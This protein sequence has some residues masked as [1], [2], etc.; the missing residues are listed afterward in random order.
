MPMGKIYFSIR[1]CFVFISL[2]I[3]SQ[4][5]SQSLSCNNGVNISMDENCEVRLSSSLILRGLDAQEDPTNFLISV[6]TQDGAIPQDV[7]V[8][9]ASTNTFS[10]TIGPQG[11]FLL[12]S[13]PG[14]FI[15]NV[16]RKS[17]GISCWSDLRVED[18]L[19]PFAVDCPC[20]ADVP[21][22]A[23]CFLSCAAIPEFRGSSDVSEAAGLN[24]IFMDNCEL[25]VDVS[26]R[27]E[28]TLDTG[29]GNYIITRTW[30]SL[31]PDV[32]GT[33]VPR[34]LRCTQRFFFEPA[35]IDSIIP[36]SD[37]VEVTCGIDTDPLSLRDYFSDTSFFSN[38][39]LDTALVRAYPSISTMIPGFGSALTVIGEGRSGNSTDNFC[40]VN[41]SYTDSPMIPG[42]G[43]IGFKFVRTWNIIDWCSNET[44]PNVTQIIKVSDTEGPRF[45]IPDTIV[46]VSTRS[47]A[48]FA[49]IIVPAPD[50]LYD[51]CTATSDLVWIAFVEIDGD[52]IEA[53]SDNGNLLRNLPVGTHT[54]TYAVTD[55]CDNTSEDTTTIV[56]KDLIR[57]V[58]IAK[59]SIKITFASFNGDCTAKV[60]T[61]NIDTG[62]FDNCDDDLEIGI[63]RF[64]SD[65][66]FG[67]SVK[68]DGDDL[69]GVSDDGN[70]TGEVIIELEVRDDYDNVNLA[71]TTVKLQDLRSNVN[72]TCGE[73]DIDVNCT[74]SLE[75]EII[76]NAPT[77]ILSGCTDRPLEV[78]NL[79]RESNI[80][81]SCNTGTAIV[82]YFIEG[83]SDVICTKNFELSDP[84]TI[85]II[86]PEAEITVT[87]S[88]SDFGDPIIT[89]GLCSDPNVSE[90]IRE[91][92]TPIG[93]GFCRTLIREITVTDF[94]SFVPNSGDS[95]G[96]FRFT[97]RIKVEDNDRPSIECVNLA[98]DSNE[99][100]GASGIVLSASG[101]DTGICND[102]LT[103]FAA[104][105]ADGDGV[106]EIELEVTGEENVTAVVP[107]TIPVGLHDVRWRALDSCGNSDEAV[108]LLTVVDT[109][110]PRVRCLGAI[111]TASMGTDGTV[112][113]WAQDFDPDG[114]STDDC[115]DVLIYSF[116]PTIQNMPSMTFT[117]EDLVA[118]VGVVIDLD[119]HVFD[120]SGN[121]DFCSVTIR[122]DDNQDAC[123][124]DSAHNDEEEEEEEEEDGG[125]GATS[126]ISG[127]IATPAGDRLESA[128]VQNLRISENEVFEDM[129]DIEGTYAFSNNAL[130]TDYEISVSLEGDVLNGVSTLDLVLIQRHILGLSTLDSPYKL[131]AADVTEDTRIS[132][133]DLV[134]I[135]NLILGR[136]QEFASGNSWR[137]IPSDFV[138]ADPSFPW[139]ITESIQLSQLSGDMTGQ[140]FIGI[141]LG[142]VNNNAIANSGLAGARSHVIAPTVIQDKTYKAGERV[143]VDIPLVQY[144]DV[145]GL[146][147][148]L[149]IP[150]Q[151]LPQVSIDG[152][153]L[154]EEN[155]VLDDGKLYLS[156]SAIGGELDES[157]VQIA[158]ISAS[159]GVLSD[160]LSMMSSFDSEIYFGEDLDIG[161][162]Q[163]QYSSIVD[164]EIV[165]YQN[166]PNPF[167]DQTSIS[168]KIGR[169][170]QVDLTVF[171]LTGRQLYGAS[172]VYES[173][174][175]TIILSQ[176]ILDQDGVL[177]YQINFE[178][179]VITKKM[180]SFR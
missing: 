166:T 16:V 8:Y 125:D 48:C 20:A 21:P 54:V 157:I 130:M 90:R 79:I 164:E 99:E 156:L 151:W 100:C 131:I 89:G 72:I 128:V 37:R 85:S 115:D 173:G 56:I 22:S 83:S 59:R 74:A 161:Q 57:P 163:L 175:H 137:F 32:D 123:D 94:C 179:K 11:E 165:L 67:D 68:F 150:G 73:L 142:D 114:L 78:T 28:L 47:D 171:D 136:T 140:D 41:A 134:Q 81:T 105:D 178:D 75:E 35:N 168:F 180:I 40:Q 46:N 162:L 33:M 103:W 1:Y 120:Q 53:N 17:D 43:G 148:G 45:M 9:D 97:Q 6:T 51:N 110:A 111:S 108:C 65:D 15:V 144:Q 4:S 116:S 113:I 80:N 133:I 145:A 38:P 42:C 138:F 174:T 76:N 29:C 87:C 98:V 106:F 146:Q 129:T 44:L 62:S 158:F 31:I 50:T 132:A 177:Y 61:Q 3:S 169:E 64:E 60:F 26:F 7:L 63:R 126:F 13:E 39:N 149:E 2:L 118:G 88:D 92:D 159:T 172:A 30:T 91:F 55:L 121:S 86:W 36:P 141:K 167:T 52:R 154:S 5:F 49:D 19:L 122:I 101:S 18:K 25:T 12:F 58:A 135:R 24:P 160:D 152:K 82:D 95:I 23:E 34:D 143:Q 147:L 124:N 107:G 96:V 66:P 109:N 69:T 155:Y 84:D 153:E 170:G 127:L 119:I 139:P 70:P 176:D 112:T 77:V 71:W 14:E 10:D 104:I 93:L 27:D 117:C 102:G